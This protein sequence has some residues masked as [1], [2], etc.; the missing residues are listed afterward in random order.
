MR[1]MK[2]D[3]E[4]IM[5]VNADNEEGNAEIKQVIIKHK[6]SDFEDKK[7]VDGGAIKD[8]EGFFK[9]LM[10]RDVPHR[11][12]ILTFAFIVIGLLLFSLGFLK[13]L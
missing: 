10:R 4:L 11:A 2:K 1:D 13:N 8:R 5:M 9:F 12:V 3:D 6:A 7:D